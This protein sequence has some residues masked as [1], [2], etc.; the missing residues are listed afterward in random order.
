M[1]KLISVLCLTQFG[2]KM[3]PTVSLK[4]VLISIYRSLHIIYYIYFEWM[5][6]IFYLHFF[7]RYEFSPFILRNQVYHLMNFEW[8]LWISL[9]LSRT[10][11]I[12]LDT[13][14][15]QCPSILQNYGCNASNNQKIPKYIF[16]FK[17][18]RKPY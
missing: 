2:V 3:W 12:Q 8:V 18:A 1:N 5:I 11:C 6:S 9:K 17:T 7:Y 16:T 14:I 15:A 4:Y 10:S 13:A